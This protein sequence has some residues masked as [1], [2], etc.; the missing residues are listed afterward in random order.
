MPDV[1]ELRRTTAGAPVGGGAP[2]PDRE[3]A[4]KAH[5]P[6][7]P[8]RAENLA[9]RLAMA[10]AALW[11]LD[12]AFWHREPGTSLGDHLASGLVP[13]ALAAVL[14]LAYPLL[15]RGARALASLTAG[16]LMAVAGVVDGARHVAVDRLGGDDI[17]AIL[18]GGAG[19]ALLVLGTALLWCSRRLDERPLRRYLRRALVGAV[20]AFGAIFV[21][22][23]VAFAIVS[24][25][26]ARAPVERVDLGRPYADV[27]LTTT[28]GLRLAAW[29]VPSRNGAAVIAF[30]GRK[31]P[32]R[33][34]RMLVR[35]G[36]GVLLLDRRG[37]GE[38]QGD[39]NA[40]GWGGDPD[41]RAAVAY[42]R[43]RPDV[44]DGR[45]GGLGLS[46]GGELLLQAA[47]HDPGL[48]AIVSEGAGLRSAAEQKHMPGTPREPIRWIAPI[49]METVAGVVL[50][51]QAP[52]PDLV[53]LMPRIA[54]RPVLLI[55]GMKGNDDESL[56][57][58]Y[59]DAGGPTTT[60]WEIQRAGHTGGMSTVPV[61]YEHRVI[62]FFDRALLRRP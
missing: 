19:A 36:Y 61:E 4:R 49:T 17:T 22:M 26:K 12:D 45:I 29:Y 41:L 11:V 14:A 24:N 31:G 33:H 57:R 9:F 6:Q 55:R 7:A 47:A 58:A 27:S 23:P 50:S 43:T 46:V 30:P 40:R 3:G 44:H 59:G 16:A 51:N 20:A 56:N 37:E 48:R 13:V 21:V 35:H 25:H 60:L 39:F 15:R 34:A 1:L 2:S 8:T 62:G 52:P 42:L 32:A 18:A 28:D 38:S 5:L 53:D 54:P 10:T